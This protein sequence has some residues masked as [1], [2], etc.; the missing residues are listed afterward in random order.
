MAAD[1][2]HTEPEER[3]NTALTSPLLTGGTWS[4]GS[5]QP[6][7]LRMELPVSADN[8]VAALYGEHDRLHQRD[9]AD[10]EDIW[11][12]V[13]L[14]VV[15]DGLHAV[16]EL[17]EG[18]REQ[19]QT[20]TLAASDWLAYCRHRVAMVVGGA[21]ETRTHRCPCGYATD[22]VNA[23]DEHLRETEG[24]EPEHFEVLDGWSLEQM[25]GWQPVMAAGA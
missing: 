22:D 12:N 9:L 1:I 3:L 25:L 19:E 20:D 8:M 14:V 16:E 23:F 18:I 24:M 10:D 17:A 6:Y 7:V 15:Q 4:E 5:G 11:V 21:W 13:A 2:C